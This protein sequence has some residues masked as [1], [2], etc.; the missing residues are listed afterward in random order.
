MH[1]GK[2]ISMSMPGQP[3]KLKDISLNVV[4]EGNGA[5][6]LLLHG[7]TIFTDVV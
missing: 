7:F 2:G 3:I 5:P 4:V 1:R 6:V